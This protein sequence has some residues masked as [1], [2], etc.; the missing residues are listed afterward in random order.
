MKSRHILVVAMLWI[1]SLLGV[2]LWAQGGAGANGVPAQRSTP[3]VVPSV[4]TGDNLGFIPTPS[5]TA[6]LPGEISGYFVVKMHG[7]WLRVTIA[8][9]IIR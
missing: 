4:I 6:D 5:G 1:V 2:G 3:A 9:H 8:P 7:Q